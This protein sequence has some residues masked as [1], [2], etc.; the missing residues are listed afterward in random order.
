VRKTSLL[1]LA[2]LFASTAGAQAPAAPGQLSVHWE[3]LTAA[4][5]RDAIARAKGTCLLP[6]GILEKH[7]P[8]RPIGNDLISVRYVS[9]KAA[10]Q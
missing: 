1:S 3:E 8:H 7:G 10:Q 5:F 9:L 2:L 6:I 4:D